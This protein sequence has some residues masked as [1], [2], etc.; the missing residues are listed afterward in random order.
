[1]SVSGKNDPVVRQIA[2]TDIVEAL[3]SGLRDFQK[4]PL[5]GLVFGALYAAGG[6]AIV[7]SVVSLGMSYLAYPSWIRIR[8]NINI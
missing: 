1:M 7:L 6:L 5:Y 2:V 3:G 4:A 8:I